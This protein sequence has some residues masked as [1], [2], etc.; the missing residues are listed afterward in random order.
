LEEKV[1]KAAEARAPEEQKARR[2]WKG[3]PSWR[4]C[5]HG[6]ETS[7]SR[8]KNNESHFAFNVLFNYCANINTLA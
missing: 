2:R 3:M 5:L 8:N 4:L 6:R 1:K 7:F